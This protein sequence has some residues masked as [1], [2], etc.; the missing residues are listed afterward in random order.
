[1][2]VEEMVVRWWGWWLVRDLVMRW[3]RWWLVRDLIQQGF[4]S[5]LLVMKNVE[6]VF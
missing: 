5:L 3:W 1:L 2:L 6:G 4:L